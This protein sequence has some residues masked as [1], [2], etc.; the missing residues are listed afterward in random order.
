MVGEWI[1]TRSFA[2]FILSRKLRSFASLRM[3]A[4]EGVRMTGGEGLKIT[5]AGLRTRPFTEF[6]LSQILRFP[7][8]DNLVQNDNW[9]RIKDNKQEKGS[10]GQ[11]GIY[12]MTEGEG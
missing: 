8:N 11:V 4:G 12:G 3:T 1:K 2:E 10:G 7:Q 6:T 5:R 9:R